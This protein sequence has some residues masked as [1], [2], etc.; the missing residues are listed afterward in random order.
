MNQ[1]NRYLLKN[2]NMKFLPFILFMLV[3]NTV[4][5]GNSAISNLKN[6]MAITKYEAEDAELTGV[7]IAKSLPGFSGTGYMDGGSFDNDGDKI[8]FTVNVAKTASYPL[9]IRF[10][11]TCGICEKA[12]KIS[13]NGASSKYTTF[14]GT[15]SSWQDLH[16]G[17]IDLKAGNNTIAISKSWGW[18]HIDYIGIGENDT[19]PPSA[20]T[21][22]K[23][24]NVTQTSII[25]SWNT[26]TDNVSVSGYDIY[27]GNTLK[28][29]TID[30]TFTINNV[31][32]N[33]EYP[34][35]TIKAKD[36]AGNI[37]ASSNAISVTTNAC[38]QYIL[39]VNNGSGSGSFYSGEIVSIAA[40][41][42]PAGKIFD[43][44]V[45]S[46]AVAN[47]TIA[48]TTLVMPESAIEITATYKDIDPAKLLDP[49]ATAA[50]VKLWDYL[51]SIYGQKMLTGC[52]TESQ[53]GGNDNVEKCT[54]ET[55]AIWGQD[56]NSWYRNRTEQNWINTWNT[57]IQGFKTAHKRGQILQVNW[58]WQMPSSKVNGAYTRDAW[59]RNSAGNE[60]MMTAQ[61]WNDIVTPGTDLYNTMIEDIDYH[62]VN[63][64]KKIV[65]EKGNPIPI[66]FRPLHEID[67]GWFWWTCTTDPTKTAKLFMIL[68]DRIM[69]YH[70]CHNLIWVYNPG[71]ICN[72]GSWPP[73]QISELPRR[74]LFYPGD[75]YCDITGIDLYEYD[76]AGRGTYSN[77]G[78]TYR[79][80]FNMMKAIAPSKMI[81]LCEAEGLPDPEKCFTDPDFA[82]WLF[83][84]P[85]FSDKY[86][87]NTTGATRDLCEWNKI[88]F[89]SEYVINAGDFV[90]SSAQNISGPNK[91]MFNVYPNPTKGYFYVELPEDSADIQLFDLNGKAVKL[92]QSIKTCNL[93]NVTGIIPGVYILRAELS[94]GSFHST[95]I[96]MN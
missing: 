44:W 36:A 57:N 51:K 6:G 20:P 79:D 17:D 88:Q 66:I 86:T 42:A 69:N 4:F 81:A 45:G 47:S 30:T 29:T 11:N 63:F 1:G 5:A 62:V 94:D 73:Y 93:L 77:T 10:Q 90:I 76:P 14:S 87:D 27:F 56:M 3:L 83:C 31:I 95:K 91:I 55:P 58:H 19:T 37:S 68:Q 23:S 54:G 35:I 13:V 89:K 96:I 92:T 28:A 48:I 71:V 41:P 18:T 59:G 78:K 60:Q 52:W 82:P 12:Q 7:V 65:D 21:N 75:A 50:T 15:S 26:A 39:T 67:G 80:A 43:K 84:L 61:Q 85:W 72:G 38:K 22:L 9:I 8:T 25:L 34:E 24:E 53:F 70:G 16:A 64:L 46:G 40:S 2:N 49:N 32:C 33:T 74:K